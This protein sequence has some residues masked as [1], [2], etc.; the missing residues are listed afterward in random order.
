MEISI[1]SKIRESLLISNDID[2][3][4][5]ILEFLKNPWNSLDTKLEGVLFEICNFNFF[6]EIRYW[7]KNSPDDYRVNVT[8][9][10]IIIWE[11]FLKAFEL[12]NDVIIR[13]NE[14]NIVYYED[15]YLKSINEVKRVLDIYANAKIAIT[16]FENS[17]GIDRYL[18]RVV[19]KDV[20]ILEY[21]FNNIHKK[22]EE[23]LEK[24]KLL[25]ISKWNT[26]NIY[27]SIRHR[28]I[29][30]NI[31]NQVCTL[32]DKNKKRVLLFIIDGF[33]MGQYMWSKKVVSS[34]K[35]FT[36]NENIFD[37]LSVNKLSDEFI[38]GAPLV[39]DT[40]AGMS[41]IFIGKTSKDTRIFAS[42]IKREESNEIIS[43]KSCN[44][45]DFNKL[46][47]TEFSSITSEVDSELGHAN[48]Y[49]CSKYNVNNI[50][51]FSKYIFDRAIVKSITPPERVYSI[52][53]ENYREFKPGLDV[54][55]ITTIDNSGHVMGSFSQFERYEHEKIN[56]MLKN[57]LIDLAKD[58]PNFF[59]GNTCF[60]ITADH[61]MTESYKINISRNEI[62]DVLET[63]GERGRC[64]ED[65]RAMFIYGISE[66]NV[67]N[68]KNVLFKYFEENKIDV[69]ILSK[70]DIEFDSF[71]PK[72]DDRYFD[73]TPD[74]VILLVSEGIFY[75]KNIGEN[76]MH[77]GGHGGNSVDEVFV[78]FI[79]IEINEKL[80][81]NIRDRFLKLT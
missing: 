25:F 41:Q 20:F 63:V 16:N 80:L 23:I 50:S 47:S 38:L 19:S 5:Q 46:A 72:E 28:L 57:F 17:L 9:G 77:F 52:L 58:N 3:Y 71:M 29:N 61:G 60:M 1:L 24:Y 44:S 27:E 4:R 54:V 8:F 65:N 2:Y 76:L 43:I 49:Y 11:V 55:Y 70:G 75:S 59:D 39:T 42:T 66:F 69:K 68:S 64:V 33:G 74:I 78:P 36:Y 12:L 21:K 53:Q 48:I 79:N 62:I 14:V 56:T 18:D 81:I 67:I 13:L 10:Q 26:T 45:N 37:W 73:I 30:K 15:N 32:Q 35:S 51:G 22:V 31:Y 34:N 40:A 6:S 7:Y